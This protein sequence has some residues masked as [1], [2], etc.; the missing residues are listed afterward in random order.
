MG[1]R[2]KERERERKPAL[3]QHISQ[4]IQWK[5]R[6]R[7]AWEWLNTNNGVCVN[8]AEGN[9]R[10]AKKIQVCS[11]DCVYLSPEYKCIYTSDV[12]RLFLVLT[13]QTVGVEKVLTLFVTFDATLGATHALSSDTPQQP[14]A[15][16]AVG[17]GGGGPHLKIVRGGGGDRVDQGLQGLFIHVALLQ[18]EE[19]KCELN[20]KRDYQKEEKAVIL[21]R[22]SRT[23]QFF[24]SKSGR[25][26]SWSDSSFTGILHQRLK[27]WEKAYLR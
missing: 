7:R 5:G 21:L 14:L 12:W 23:H 6:G 2:D 25:S 17:G 4:E 26:H 19:N 8:R 18:R 9:S 16:V 3:W 11:A 13:L 15:F 27:E 1:R 22:R 24:I 20:V 10:G